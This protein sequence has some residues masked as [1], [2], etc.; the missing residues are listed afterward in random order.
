MAEYFDW[1]N[2]NKREY[3]H[4][5]DFNFGAKFHESQ[6]KE[7]AVLRALY[8]LLSGR[9]K[10]DPVVFIG[11]DAAIPKDTPYGILRHLRKQAAGVDYSV[12]IYD[13]Y[14][15]V[16]CLF[17]D[18]ETE[19]R[20]EIGYFL[21][22]ILRSGSFEN[23]NEYGIDIRRPFAGLFC[24][25]GKSFQYVLNHTKKEYY[26]LSETPI[27]YKDG[28]PCDYIDPLPLLLGLGRSTEPGMWLGD[29]IG[30]SDAV[31]NDYKPLKEI[32]LDW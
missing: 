1:V 15:N 27:L 18:A 13:S 29:I 20:E 23:V 24:F 4:P 17:H 25:T 8:E 14:R 12:Y 28:E 30:V 10:G 9:W 7:N 32:R 16:S 6:H 21:E 5:H 22:D 2:V 19:V 3:L 26:S 11:D 31:G